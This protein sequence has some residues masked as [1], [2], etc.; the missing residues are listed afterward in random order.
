MALY[1]PDPDHLYEP[2]ADESL[3]DHVL[4]YLARHS[5]ADLAEVLA[6]VA[7]AV[8]LAAAL[9]R[10]VGEPAEPEPLGTQGDDG[11]G[12]HGGILRG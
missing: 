7:P 8:D 11:G 1:R 6:G 10:A 9:R 12:S 2:S 4:S 3:G 5:V